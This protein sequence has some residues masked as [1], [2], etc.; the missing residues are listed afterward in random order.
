MEFSKLALPS[1]VVFLGLVSVFSSLV[2]SFLL[3]TSF[4]P[5]LGW[6][7]VHFCP[8]GSTL[9]QKWT[10]QASNGP[11]HSTWTHQCAQIKLSLNQNLSSNQQS[12]WLMLK[13]RHR[14]AVYLACTPYRI[15]TLDHWVC[16]PQSPSE[17]RLPWFATSFATGPSGRATRNHWT[18]RRTSIS[19][20]KNKFILS[21][22]IMLSHLIQKEIFQTQSASIQNQK[23][24]QM[25]QKQTVPKP[26][27]YHDFLLITAI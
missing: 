19:T 27:S 8:A 13:K 3:L 24:H 14:L 21:N 22:R 10:H 25:A 6:F 7:A 17:S 9:D 18:E 2:F 4:H 12:T 26:L 15:V 23:L 1:M 20:T 11:V 5:L 16:L